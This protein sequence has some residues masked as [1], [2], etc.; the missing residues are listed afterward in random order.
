MAA[1][2][3]RILAVTLNPAIDMSFAT[4]HLRHTVKVRTGNPEFMPGGG[5]TNVARVI[6]ELGGDVEL[7]YLSGGTSGVLYDGLVARYPLYAHRVAIA[8]DVRLA[9]TIHD[10][11]TDYEY[12]FVPEGPEV[13]VNEIAPVFEMLDRFQEGIVVA[14]GSLPRGLSSGVYGQFAK[15]VASRPGVRLVV[16]TSGAALQ[17]ALREGGLFLAKPNVHELEAWHGS[18]IDDRNLETVARSLVESGAVE[19][20]VVTLGRDGAILVNREQAVRLPSIPV[21]TRSAVGAGD[22]FVGAM[23]LKLAGGAGLDEAFRYGLAAGAAA[24]ITEG[25]ALCRKA[26]VERLFRRTTRL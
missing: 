9:T 2:Q 1:K 3:A 21:R 19:N 17:A 15:A 8:G 24:A 16:D 18:A 4:P 25:A 13:G 5:G 20:L 7:V 10:A 26:D 12:R 11:E 6:A 23:V 22:S 14:S